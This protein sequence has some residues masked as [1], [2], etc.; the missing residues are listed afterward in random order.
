VQQRKY[1]IAGT[2]DIKQ[3]QRIM[4]NGTDEISSN[5]TIDPIT[6]LARANDFM[7]SRRDSHPLD[8]FDG[9]GM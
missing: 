8:D 2:L 3:I 9:D 1:G 4:M 5:E 7:N 6:V